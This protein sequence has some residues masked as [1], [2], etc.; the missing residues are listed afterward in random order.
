MVES[1]EHSL[2]V[3]TKDHKIW[4]IATA[5]GATPEHICTLDEAAEEGVIC[6][7]QNVFFRTPSLV[8]RASTAEGDCGLID[9]FGS[10]K[11]IRPQDAD[12]LLVGTDKFLNQIDLNTGKVRQLSTNNAHNASCMWKRSTTVKHSSLAIRTAFF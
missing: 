3:G 7:N 5:K 4:R 6:G 1:D 2:W 12:H 8:Y 11:T 9:M 10:P